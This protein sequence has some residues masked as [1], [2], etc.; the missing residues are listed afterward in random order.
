MLLS[1]MPA[2]LA[3]PRQAKSGESVWLIA[4][5]TPPRTEKSHPRKPR[6]AERI[7]SDLGRPVPA[8]ENISLPSA[9]NRWLFPRC[10]APARGA[11][12]SSRTL[13]RD[14]MDAAALR[15]MSDRRAGQ[16]VSGR[17]VRRTSGVV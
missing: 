17:T 11:Y 2:I 12:A 5:R 15:A 9:P 4:P 10:L 13:A 7:Q 16:L 1:K 3:Q 8:G 14:A 6:F